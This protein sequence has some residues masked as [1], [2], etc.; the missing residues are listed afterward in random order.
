M[1]LSIPRPPGARSRP[2][3]TDVGRENQLH[4]LIDVVIEPITT[5]TFRLA[6]V[7]G[8]VLWG[9]VASAINSAQARV[10]VHVPD[11]ARQASAAAVSMSGHQRLARERNPPGPGFRRTSCCLFYRLAPDRPQA[12]CGDCVL[13]GRDG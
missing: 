13:H 12:V 9:N 1:P 2:P 11:L 5:A 6:R 3:G 10:S 8:R 7:S 4:E